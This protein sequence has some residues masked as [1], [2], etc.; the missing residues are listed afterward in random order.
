MA[1][2]TFKILSPSVPRVLKDFVKSQNDV[3]RVIASRK[4]MMCGGLWMD[5]PGMINMDKNGNKSRTSVHL[6]KILH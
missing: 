1:E 5:V 2:N 4:E 6:C 3:Y